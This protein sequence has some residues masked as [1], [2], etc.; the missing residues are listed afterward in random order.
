MPPHPTINFWA[1]PSLKI[2]PAMHKIFRKTLI[3]DDISAAQF[4]LSCI[5]AYIS[6]ELAVEHNPLVSSGS[7]TKFRYTGNL[8]EYRILLKTPS[9]DLINPMP[10]TENMIE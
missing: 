7:K 6:G 10:M 9:G 1:S 4:F 5:H 2:P 3:D 8:D